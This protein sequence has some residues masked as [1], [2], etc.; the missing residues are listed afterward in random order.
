[1]TAQ[2][3]YRFTAAVTWN[4]P[5][6]PYKTP[7]IYFVRIKKVVRPS[8]SEI[9]FCLQLFVLMSRAKLTSPHH[10]HGYAGN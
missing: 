1:M 2:Q 6:Y 10:F 4:P 9:T 7:F 5:V 8:V 3:D